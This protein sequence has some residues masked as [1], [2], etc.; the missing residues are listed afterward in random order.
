MFK[1]LVFLIFLNALSSLVWAHDLKD[2]R[3]MMLDFITKSEQKK[4]SSSLKNHWNSQ[5]KEKFLDE[6]KKLDFSSSD[7]N[8]IIESLNMQTTEVSPER[9]QNYLNY[10]L[11]LSTKKQKNAL[12]DLAQLDAREMN[13]KIV[14]KFIDHE[15]KIQE[16]IAKKNMN[17]TEQ[18]RYQELYY[19][20][21]ALR[22]NEVNKNASKDFKRFNFSL[23]FGTLAASYVFYNMNKD[24]NAEWFEKLGYDLGVTLLFTVVGN[25]IQT[26]PADTQL[27]KSLK[28]YFIGRVLGATDLVIYDPIFNHERQKAEIRINELKQDPNYKSKIE[29]L[30][31]L[32]KERGIYRQYKDEIIHSLKKL[33]EGISLGING[34]SIDENGIDWN[35]LTHQD[36]DRP[37]VQDVLVAAAMAQIYNESK[38]EWIDTEDKGLDRYAFNTVYYGA[39][40]PK[41]IAQNFITYRM[42]CMGQDNPKLA[43]TKAV[44]FNVSS[45]FIMNQV[46]FGYREKAINQ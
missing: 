18:K 6:I 20:C 46:L 11:S 32:Y 19:G 44:L 17:L 27:A 43:F 15:E 39:Q 14:G 36:L 33:P 42:L 4:A 40:I 21:R 1:T 10:V 8:V 45:N 30:M 28:N 34:N 7:I 25:N 2:C 22:P 13:S 5:E 29:E 41:S 31:K 9:V 38:G 23:G 16:V 3:S 26:N 37:L 12:Y 24:I 35:N